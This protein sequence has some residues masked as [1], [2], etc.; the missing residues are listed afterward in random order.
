MSF[1]TDEGVL[2]VNKVLSDDGSSATIFEAELVSEGSKTDAVLKTY[3]ENF[4]HPSLEQEVDNMEKFG[5]ED[6]FVEYY[7]K[8][9]D[10]LPTKKMPRA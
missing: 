7:G 6:G 5:K 9:E 8:V 4:Q 3:K 10:E 2:R 1:Q